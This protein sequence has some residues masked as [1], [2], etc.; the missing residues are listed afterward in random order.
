MEFT[1]NK[2][3]CK[4]YAIYSIYSF[5]RDDADCVGRLTHLALEDDIH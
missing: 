3:N 1:S 2:S 4:I 5:N